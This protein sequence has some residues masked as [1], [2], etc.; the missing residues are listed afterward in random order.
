MKL[1]AVIALAVSCA[2]AQITTLQPGGIVKDDRA[3]INNNFSYLNTQLTN[4]NTQLGLKQATSIELTSLGNL[5]TTGAIFRIGTGA[6]T[7][8]AIGIGDL[9]MG[10]SPNTVAYGDHLHTGV[11]APLA[12]VH[13]VADITN[14]YSTLDG[15]YQPLSP[16]LTQFAALNGCANGNV[17]V[18]TGGSWLCGTVA[19]GSG[20]GTWGSITGTLSAQTDLNTALNGKLA[21]SSNLSDLASATTARTNL[22]L[23]TA[24]TQSTS[25]FLQ[26]GNNLS[27]LGSAATARANLG[28]GTIATQP[29]AF[30]IGINSSAALA[31]ITLTP[32][33]DVVSSTVKRFAPSQT[34]RITEWQT[35]T[36]TMLAGIRKDGDFV[37]P[38][39]PDGC[40]TWSSGALGSTGAT[41]GTSSGGGTPGGTNGQIQY[42]NAG[43]FGG[44]PTTGSG[45]VVMANSPTM[46][47]PTI[48]GTPTLQ[49]STDN[50][51]Q[52]RFSMAGVTTGTTRTLTIPD[53]SGTAML[54]STAVQASQM[55]ALS[56]DVSSSAGSASVT[57]AKVN[58]IT[59]SGTPS[60]GY[61]PTATSSTTATWQTPPSGISS[62]TGANGVHCVGTSS[63]TCDLDITVAN[64][65][66]DDQ[67]I[68]GYKNMSGGRLR[69]PEATFA[70]SPSTPQTGTKF[71]FTDAGSFGKC[72]GGGTS[73]AECRWNGSAWEPTTG[74]LRE[75]QFV[76]GAGT[77]IAAA[78]TIS[79]PRLISASTSGTLQKLI[80]ACGTGPTGANLTFALKINGTTTATLTITAGSTTGNTTSFSTPTL[81]EGDL[82]TVVVGTV[83]SSIPGKDCNLIATVK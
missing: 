58:G 63:V 31:T 81:A 6:H 79:V 74:F 71:L 3:A 60:V 59:I 56:G 52:L 4:V 8:R 28:L 73:Y 72:S 67:A 27:D 41:C 70:S 17:P 22:G 30:F 77:S 65:L 78:D 32:S 14:L 45:N 37:Q 23:G 42:N 75:I 62:V 38:A 34:A 80:G 26:P 24:A 25:A 15:R 29:A 51:K 61:V 46:T 16:I 43:A 44:L 18:L 69:L 40:A 39:Q 33:S 53:A 5:G 82:L 49:D 55:P 68:T 35:E 64:T 7:A 57:V 50:T 83:G 20:G 11:Y 2:F 76:F 13:L 47:T 12:H 9:P 66:A 19:T 54:T 21:A 1:L 36:G 10:T 48:V